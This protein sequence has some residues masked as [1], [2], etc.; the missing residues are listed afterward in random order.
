MLGVVIIVRPILYQTML[1]YTMLACGSN[2]GLS[3]LLQSHSSE[4]TDSIREMATAMQKK[5]ACH[6]VQTGG[7]TQAACGL[8]SHLASN[9]TYSIVKAPPPALSDCR[10]GIRSPRMLLAYAKAGRCLRDRAPG[11]QW[12]VR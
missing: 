2:T 12:H 11:F 8:L 7:A 9:I 5:R 10:L 1:S 4:I 6:V 3:A